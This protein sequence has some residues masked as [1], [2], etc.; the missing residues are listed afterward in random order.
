[1]ERGDHGVRGLPAQ[2]Y[3]EIII[4]ESDF[5]LANATILRRTLAG[6][7]VMIERQ[8]RKNRAIATRVQV[9]FK[10]DFPVLNYSRSLSPSRRGMVILGILDSLYQDLQKGT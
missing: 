6:N 4:V 1:M 3:V 2:L 10:V 5:G 8:R 7:S 9:N